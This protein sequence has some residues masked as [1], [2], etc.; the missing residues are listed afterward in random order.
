M[1]NIFTAYRNRT[2]LII[3]AGQQ[4]RSI[5]PYEPFLFAV[6]ATELPKPYVSGATSRRAPRMC[7]PP[8]RARITRQ[9]IRH[10]VLRL[11]QFLS[12]TGIAPLNGSPPAP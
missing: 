10:V 7:R 1:G 11:C 3:T 12:M 6:D 8:L 2:P 9:R 4:A 5:L